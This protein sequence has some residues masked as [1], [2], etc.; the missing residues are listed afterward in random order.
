MKKIILSIALIFS[1]LAFY[2]VN[3][4]TLIINRMK[5][6]SNLEKP[7]KGLTKQNV[8]AKFGEPQTKSAAV[9]SP[10]ITV[11]HYPKF[12]V[13]FEHLHVIH[14]VINQ[15]TKHEKGAKPIK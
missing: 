15:A 14:A 11:W 8:L 1:S 5:S 10:P 13:Y 7:S 2:S 3:A 4:D 6:S 12:K 9:G